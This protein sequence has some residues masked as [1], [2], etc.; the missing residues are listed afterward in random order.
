MGWC[1]LATDNPEKVL[2]VS[3]T[4]ALTPTTPYEIQQNPVPQV[5][6]ANFKTGVRE[7]FP[8]GLVERGEDL[9]LYYGAAEVSVAGARVNKKALVDA[10]GLEIKFNKSA[11]AL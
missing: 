3:V 7:V 9:I 11:P 4:P 1:V 5:D 2:Y 10:L 6:M 8:Q